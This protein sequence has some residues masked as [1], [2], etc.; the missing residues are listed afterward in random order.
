MS[1]IT[2]FVNAIIGFLGAMLEVVN[3]TL[4]LFQDKGLIFLGAIM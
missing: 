3:E 2:G 4:K 1:T